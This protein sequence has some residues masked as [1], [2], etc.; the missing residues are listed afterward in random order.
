M[1]KEVD[2]EWMNFVKLDW[3]EKMIDWMIRLEKT[4]LSQ[5]F[6]SAM[7]GLPRVLRAVSEEAQGMEVKKIWR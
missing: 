2:D 4:D 1:D 3:W 5:G 6:Q 7:Q